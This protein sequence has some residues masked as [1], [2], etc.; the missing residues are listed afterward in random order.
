MEAVQ[1]PENR[2]M[3]DT[4]IKVGFEFLVASKILGRVC[5]VE[6][7][8]NR[9]SKQQAKMLFKVFKNGKEKKTKERITGIQ[10]P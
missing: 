2:G 3:S 6:A 4:Y 5:L 7:S 1:Y 9:V 10:A 8:T